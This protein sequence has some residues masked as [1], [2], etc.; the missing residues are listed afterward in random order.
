MIQG[1]IIQKCPG[2]RQTFL[3]IPKTRK[4]SNWMK[5]S[6]KNANPKMKE[7]LELFDKDLKVA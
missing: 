4:I 6:I 1:L 3:I 2:F 7:M 5:N